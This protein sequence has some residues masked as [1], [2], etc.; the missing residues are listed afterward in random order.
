MRDKYG[1]ESTH[2]FATCNLQEC[3]TYLQC[4]KNQGKGEKVDGAMPKELVDRQAHCVELMS[5]MSIPDGI[6]VQQL[7][8]SKDSKGSKKKSVDALLS[9]T[10]Q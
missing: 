7:Q 9:L 1:H 3:G 8:Y 10:A 4:K 5:C 2:R 6:L